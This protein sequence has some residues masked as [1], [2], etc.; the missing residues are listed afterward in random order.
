MAMQRTEFSPRCWATSRTRRLPL[1]VGFQRVQDLRQMAVELHV[2]DGAD[3]LGDVAGGRE[4]LQPWFVLTFL[5]TVR[6]LR[7][8][9]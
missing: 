5:L 3:D 8:P 9:R 7:R 1:F 6:A 2:D 4:W